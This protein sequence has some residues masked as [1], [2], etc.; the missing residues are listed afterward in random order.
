MLVSSTEKL[1]AFMTTPV[2]CLHIADQINRVVLEIN[3]FY[4]S[5]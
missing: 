1:D 3:D 4:V 2:L 5:T